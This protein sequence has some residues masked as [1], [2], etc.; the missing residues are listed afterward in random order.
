MGDQRTGYPFAA[1]GGIDIQILHVRDRL[2]MSGDG[3][4]Y[5]VDQANHS[6]IDTC[7]EPMDRRRR[8][9]QPPPCFCRNRFV[10]MSEV[11]GIPQKLPRIPVISADVIN[12]HLIF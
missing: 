1:K 10:F 4:Q 6:A 8:V 2:D 11:V 12:S 7:R 3:M 5:I 9:E